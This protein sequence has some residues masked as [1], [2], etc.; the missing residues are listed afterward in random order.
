[1]INETDDVDS[2]VKCIMED[3]FESGL[4]EEFYDEDRFM[5]YLD[6]KYDNQYNKI[7][8]NGENN[9]KWHD[10]LEEKA[11]TEDSRSD[12]FFDHYKTEYEDFLY[13][14]LLGDDEDDYEEEF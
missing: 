1:M 12:E 13:D 2:I 10:Y 4:A 14:S 8:N 7:T 5:S 6:E 3:G 9:E 11:K